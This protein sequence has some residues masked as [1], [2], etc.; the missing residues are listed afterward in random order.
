MNG[1]S[2]NLNDLEGDI[3]LLAHLL[4]VLCEEAN[5]QEFVRPDGTRITSADRL[6]ALAT[7]ARDMGVRMVETAAACHQVVLDERRKAASH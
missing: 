2:D 6:C 7:I 3:G 5:D 4:E 1:P